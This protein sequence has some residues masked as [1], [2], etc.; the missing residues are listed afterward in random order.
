[1]PA[2]G[3]RLGDV[4]GAEH[5]TNQK[6]RPMWMKMARPVAKVEALHASRKNRVLN[7]LARIAM[8]YT[9]QATGQTEVLHA[10]ARL[11][12]NGEALQASV[13]AQR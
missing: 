7:V 4:S 5:L 8:K 1:M 9:L 13:A 12:A 6:Y 10:L 2:A 3:S 11:V